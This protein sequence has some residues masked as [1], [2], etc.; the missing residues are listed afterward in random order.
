[1][2]CVGHKVEKHWS[3]MKTIETVIFSPFLAFGELKVHQLLTENSL[4]CTET[5]NSMCNMEAHDRGSLF[6]HI[7]MHL[8]AFLRI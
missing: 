1:M 6:T 3:H 2:L 5:C 4:S 7:S 8:C